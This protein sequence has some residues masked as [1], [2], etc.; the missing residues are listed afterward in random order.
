MQPFRVHFGEHANALTRTPVNSLQLIDVDLLGMPDELF[1]SLREVLSLD[2]ACW[3]VSTKYA[4]RIE[5]LVP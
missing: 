1:A 2:F 5:I 4:I 3:Y